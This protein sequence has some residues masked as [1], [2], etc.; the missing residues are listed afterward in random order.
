MADEYTS[1]IQKKIDALPPDIRQFIYSSEMESIL[2]QIGTKHQLHIDQIGALETET[3]AVMIGLSKADEF[4]QNLTD[5]LNIDEAKSKVI[6]DDINQQLFLKIRESMKNTPKIPVPTP[7]TT[8]VSAKVVIPTPAFAPPAPV[9]KPIEAHPADL[10][11]TQKTVS[12]GPAASPPVKPQPYKADPY[13]E[14]TE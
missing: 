12:V 13:R 14:P 2:R 4:V 9:A 1:E 6:A 8:T 7:T 5:S 3:A 10:M 11:L